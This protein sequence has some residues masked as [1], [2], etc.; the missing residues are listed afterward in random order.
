MTMPVTSERAVALTL[1]RRL[2][3]LAAVGVARPLSDLS[4]RRIRQVLNLLSRG[5]RPASYEQALRARSATVTVSVRCAGLG[6]LQ[7]SI[8]TVLICRLRNRWPDWCSG[9]RTEPF[10]A[11]AWVEVD[12]VPVGEPDDVARF[13]TTLA[14]RCPEVHA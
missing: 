4:P 7:R 1:G 11:H 9:F 8:A 14:V 10:G 2:V 6:C 12:G 13:H 5:T 3:A